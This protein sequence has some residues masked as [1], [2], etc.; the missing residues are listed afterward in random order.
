MSARSAV[1]LRSTCWSLS[2]SKD[3]RSG[4]SSTTSSRKPRVPTSSENSA[5]WPVDGGSSPPEVPIVDSV[6][7]AE[8]THSDASAEYWRGCSSANVVPSRNA[9]RTGASTRYLCRNRISR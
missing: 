5:A 9:T 2:P 3:L 7:T 1:S 8:S 4:L 6:V